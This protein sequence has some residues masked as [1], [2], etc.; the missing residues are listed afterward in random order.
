MS[1][2]DCSPVNIET[3]RLV[4]TLPPPSFALA[5]VSYFTR[6]AEHLDRWEPPR[7]PSFR[8]EPY[9]AARLEQNRNEFAGDLTLRL[10]L[11]TRDGDIAGLCNFTAF[12]RGPFLNCRL[13]YSLDA[14]F[15]GHG[16]MREALDAAIAC[17]FGKL[18]FHRIEATHLLSN[19]RSA[20]L[21]RRLGF[22]QIGLAPC[23]LFIN[24]AWRDH[25]LNALVNPDPREPVITDP[26][27]RPKA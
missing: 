17:V 20:H 18:G 13:G 24:G 8:T 21:L 5:V 19:E 1:G 7:P 16:Y 15:E 23:Y 2:F 9:W 14:A 25:V 6:N 11:L 22:E 3:S 12:E 10:T 26:P 27:S 4:L